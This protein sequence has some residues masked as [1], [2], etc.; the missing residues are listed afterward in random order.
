MQRPGLYVRRSQLAEFETVGGD[1]ALSCVTGAQTLGELAQ[2][3]SLVD[4]V[5][6][7]DCA[8][9]A[10]TSAQDI[11]A[12]AMRRG[13]GARMLRR[14][15]NLADPRSES[16]WESVLRL[17]HVLTGLGPVE[18]QV[19]IYACGTLVA[20]ADLHLVGTRRYP[21]CDGAE[22][23]SRDR[24]QRDLARDKDMARLGLQRYG[25]STT[26]IAYRPGTVIADAETARGLAPDPRRLQGWWRL[27]RLSTLTA[28]GRRR[29]TERLERYQ[30]AANR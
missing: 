15:L 27:A 22:H 9:A 10:G 20:R 18:C 25:Y 3:L 11:A 19:E 2:D 4:L 7:V 24:H 29:L 23:R 1:R 28:V 6:L 13:R 12:V 16:W 30:R 17:M 5:P 21:E 26:E 14:A 8:L